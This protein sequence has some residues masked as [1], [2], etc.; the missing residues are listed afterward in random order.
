MKEGSEFNKLILETID[1]HCDDRKV[2]RLIRESLRYELDIWNR[3]IR[4]SEIEDEYEQMV[5]DV[6]K[7]RN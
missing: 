7:G 2:K 3:H 1:E 4:S 5:N 6:L